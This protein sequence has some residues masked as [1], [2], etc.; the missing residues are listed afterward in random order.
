MGHDSVVVNIIL[1]KEGNDHKS[2]M[3]AVV[4]KKGQRLTMM[5]VLGYP[6]WS[7]GPMNVDKHFSFPG[8]PAESLGGLSQ[9]L[10]ALEQGQSG[11]APRGWEASWH[12]LW[13]GFRKPGKTVVVIFRPKKGR[14]LLGHILFGP[15]SWAFNV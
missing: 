12:S 11:P 8:L 6:V 13:S 2:R 7:C 9:R 1:G 5:T 10:Y 14:S 3:W 4:A 15:F